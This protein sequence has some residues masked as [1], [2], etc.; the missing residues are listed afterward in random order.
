MARITDLIELVSN[1]DDVIV[2]DSDF[3]I[4]EDYVTIASFNNMVDGEG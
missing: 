2:N 3:F 1:G 4:G